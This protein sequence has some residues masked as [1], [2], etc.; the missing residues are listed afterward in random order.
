ML[1]HSRRY[2]L[3]IGLLTAAIGLTWAQRWTAAA[4][5]P[6]EVVQAAETTLG[7]PDASLAYTYFVDVEG[8]YRIT[9]YET[10]VRSPLDLTGGTSEEVARSLP[11]TLGDWQQIG[12]DQYIADDPAVVY[13]LNQ[14]TVALQR[15]YQNATGQ[16]VTLAIIG[17]KGEDSFLLFSHTPETCYPGRLWQVIETRRESAPLDDGTMYAQYLLTEHAESKER[18]M[19][20]FWY[21]W[22]NPRR[23]SKEG[24]LSIRV[25]LFIPQGDSEAEA[26]DRAWDFVRELFPAT[27]PWERF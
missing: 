11:A 23:D 21:L 26:L 15:A 3:I 14:P 5:M 18:L 17:N 8:W 19:V 13:Y 9:P 7:T 4:N 2:L 12:Q 20:L 10:V 27:I 16:I 22:D 25:N 1:S 6:N 24:V